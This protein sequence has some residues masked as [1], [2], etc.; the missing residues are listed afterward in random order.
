[1]P[2]PGGE[3]QTR[4]PHCRGRR[5]PV[6]RAHLH[7]LVDHCEQPLSQRLCIAVSRQPSS[8]TQT[9]IMVNHADT[10]V[11]CGTRGG[12]T[13]PRLFASNTPMMPALMFWATSEQ[14]RPYLERAC[15]GRAHALA[16]RLRAPAGAART[17]DVGRNSGQN[18]ARRLGPTLATA[19]LWPWPA[20]PAG[21]GTSANP[22]QIARAVQPRYSPSC[23][24]DPGSAG[25]HYSRLR[26]HLVSLRSG[27][28][29]RTPRRRPPSPAERRR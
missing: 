17:S 27:R 21:R 10:S 25:C 4:P 16:R 29:R 26:D 24:I 14:V 1:M 22:R 2:S 7:R 3:R 20:S 23:G 28:P 5:R 18:I 13:W 19:D 9:P 8:G 15:T 11:Y 6:D 12:C